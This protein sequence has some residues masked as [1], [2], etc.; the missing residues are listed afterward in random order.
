[1]RFIVY[2][3]GAVGGVVSAALARSGQSVLGIARGAQLDAIRT[4]GL[5]LKSPEIDEIHRFDCA[6]TPAEIDFGPDD[7]ILLCV[8]TQH[9]EA[10]LDA[11]A[12][13]GAEDQPIFCLQNGVENERRAL[14]R[15]ANVHGV[16]VMLPAT[17]LEPGKVVCHALPRFGIFDVGRYTGGTDAADETFCAA[18]TQANFAAYPQADV[19][20]SKYGKLLMNLGNILMASLG[21]GA[22][23]GD[24][25]DRLKAE[26]QAVLAAAGIAVDDVGR[27]DPRRAEHLTVTDVPG[28]PP[29][30]GSTAQSLQRGTG[31][32]ETDFLNGEIVLLGRQHGVPT[33]ANAAML[34][35]AARML[36]D[37]LKPGDLTPGELA[38]LIGLAGK[39]R[40][41]FPLP[42]GAEPLGCRHLPKRR[43]KQ[44]QGQS[45]AYGP[46][47]S[48]NGKTGRADPEIR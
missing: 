18:M 1:M 32:V 5:R 43:P 30:G 16:T 38:A 11:L 23:V 46:R 35:L 21:P 24:F 9:T 48:D 36:R 7:A 28:E 41:A 42:Q 19:M 33:P 15:F 22:E 27:D 37:D 31:S 12:A 14:R 3:V 34:R 20:R 29:L 10:A 13:A 47:E 40:P 25:R 45:P 6:A 8:K 26:A 17:F 4:G 2:G 39:G 44:G